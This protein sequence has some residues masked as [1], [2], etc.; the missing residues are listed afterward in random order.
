MIT[1]S[2]IQELVIVVDALDECDRSSTEMFLLLLPALLNDSAPSNSPKLKIL[3][4]SRT[5]AY[6][7]ERLEGHALRLAV[8]PE[9]NKS[10]IER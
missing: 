10:D 2:D 1:T 8:I 6:I 4:S 5:E 7:E 9:L 3:V